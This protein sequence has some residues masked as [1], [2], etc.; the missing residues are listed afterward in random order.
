[1]LSMPPATMMSAEPAETRSCASMTAF[2]PE[3][4]ILLM[5]VV[6][7]DFG[8]PA[9]SAAWRPG[10]CPCPAG[11][12]QPKITSSM[13]SGLVPARSMAERIAA[14]PSSGA[15]TSLKSPWKPP[16]GVRAEPT[17]TMGSGCAMGPPAECKYGIGYN[18]PTPQRHRLILRGRY[19]VGD[20]SKPFVYRGCRGAA[21]ALAF[22]L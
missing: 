1:M 14:A 9:P 16:I 15:F 10:A 8:R 3:P 5:V 17:M 6:V 12:T 4:H 7:V 22:R 2:M 11:K 21:L 18:A 20:A 13:S 19:Y